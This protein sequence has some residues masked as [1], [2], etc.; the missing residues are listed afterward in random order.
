MRRTARLLVVL[1]LVLAACGGD[2][3]AHTTT[4]TVPGSTLTTGDIGV[5]ANGDIQLTVTSEGGFAPVES[6]LD[7]MPRYVLLADGTLYYQGP[8]PA[9]FPGPLLPN[10]QVTEVTDAQMDEIRELVEELG[11]PGIDELID[12]SNA[13][14]V[15]DATTEFIT[16]YD[17]NGTHRLGVYALGITQGGG[18]TERILAT[19]LVQVLDEATATGDAR[20]YSP[21]RLQVAAGPLIPFDDVDGG[22]QP[23]PLET[24][25]TNM[26]DWAMDWRCVEVE[27]DEV[28]RLIDLFAE[29]NQA[30]RWDTGDQE[31]TI[32]ARPLL[33]GEDACGGAPQ[34]G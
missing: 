27:G 30:T 29:A 3:T 33:P 10:V 5:P 23:W 20:P 11:L 4:T 1:G 6:H 15:A 22:V 16:Y 9:I 32:K 28:G 18:S 12:D 24:A 7:R 21:D 17:E 2:D 26:P 19:E 13:E 25:F 34:G 8:V 31:L 14:M